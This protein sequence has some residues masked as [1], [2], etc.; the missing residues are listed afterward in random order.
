MRNIGEEIQYATIVE[1][2]LRS[3]TLNF[4]SKEF[5][6]EEM[7]NLKGLTLDH[8]HGTLTK[9]EMRKGGPLDMREIAFKAT[10]K[11]K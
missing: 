3:L 2:I 9:F 7:W 4:D 5:T 10:V 1:N 8:L 11:E 6:I